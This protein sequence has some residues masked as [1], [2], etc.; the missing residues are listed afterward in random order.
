MDFGSTGRPAVSPAHCC[1][2]IGSGRR[3]RCRGVASPGTSV[4]SSMTF[5]G[6]PSAMRR[7]CVRL[8]L[9]ESG[10]TVESR[11]AAGRRRY[12][13]LAAVGGFQLS[14]S[15]AAGPVIRGHSVNSRFRPHS[16]HPGAREIVTPMTALT[17]VQTRPAACAWRGGFQSACS[18]ETVAI[19]HRS[20]I[21]CPLPTAPDSRT[22]P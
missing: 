16:G 19:G 15:C 17:V 10:C 6:R 13:P 4:I 5:G 21:E 11:I 22:R 1:W 14:G 8:H 18:I 2:R 9:A 20:P 3:W 12:R 7:T